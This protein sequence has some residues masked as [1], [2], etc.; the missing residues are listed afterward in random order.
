MA[1]ATERMTVRVRKGSTN[2]GYVSTGYTGGS[3]DRLA[4]SGTVLA[5]VAKGETVTVI[6]YNMAGEAVCLHGSA[7]AGYSYYSAFLIKTTE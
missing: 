4:G 3:S 6:A 2:L 5:S 1:V 7:T